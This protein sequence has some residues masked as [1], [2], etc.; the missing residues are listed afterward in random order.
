MQ[1]RSVPT[2][3]LDLAAVTQSRIRYA[4]D[5]SELAP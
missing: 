5:I 3:V 1:Y 2:A 4:E